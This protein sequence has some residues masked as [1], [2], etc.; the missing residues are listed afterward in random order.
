MTI[1]EKIHLVYTNFRPCGALNLDSQIEKMGSSV[2]NRMEKPWSSTAAHCGN[3]N[4]VESP[5]FSLAMYVPCEIRA[6]MGGH[7]DNKALL[8]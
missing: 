5:G 8:L 3:R 7:V 4:H 2:R 6:P 1:L